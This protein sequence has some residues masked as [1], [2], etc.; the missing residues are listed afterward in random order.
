MER[1]ARIVVGFHGCGAAVANALLDG[2]TP[3][4]QWQPSKNT[5]DWLGHGIYFWEHSPGRALRWAQEHV[6]KSS[7][8]PGVVGAII[9]LGDC[10]DLLNEDITQ[11]LAKH[12]DFL[13]AGYAASS[14][15]LPTNTGAKGKLRELDCLVIN[16][17]IRR[18]ESKGIQTFQ[19]IRGAFEEGAL[20]YPGAGF[21]RETH[22][23][24]AVR[25]TACILG[26]FRPNLA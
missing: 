5:Y 6:A 21:C 17:C 23:Q 13:A 2:S 26:V 3:I 11:I 12:Y 1:F 7:G 20:A 24:I 19:T 15:P 16:D 10:F 9:Q 8:E 14:T 22:I 18:L 4:S 25:D